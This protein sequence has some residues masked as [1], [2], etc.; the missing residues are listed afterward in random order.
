VIAGT[1]ILNAVPDPDRSRLDTSH[2]LIITCLARLARAGAT[3]GVVGWLSIYPLD[4]IRSRVNAQGAGGGE[5]I[6][7]YNGAIDCAVKTFRWVDR[8]GGMES[9]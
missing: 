4:V 3:A 8:G 9:K 2:G 7:K 5:G 1:D 6:L